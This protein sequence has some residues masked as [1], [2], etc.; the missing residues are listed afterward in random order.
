MK[1]P[2]YIAA[3]ALMVN[4][5]PGLHAGP[6]DFIHPGEPQV[7]PNDSVTVTSFDGLI[8]TTHPILVTTPPKVHPTDHAL[9]HPTD[10]PVVPKGTK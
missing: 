1:L 6:S 8:P 5:A 3:I 10:Q 4:C 7:H 2:G 9:V